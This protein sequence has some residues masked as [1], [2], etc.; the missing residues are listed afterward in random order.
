MGDNLNNDYEKMKTKHKLFLKL[1]IH[2]EGLA[3]WWHLEDKNKVYR[4]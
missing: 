2:K 1:L 3:I 4:N